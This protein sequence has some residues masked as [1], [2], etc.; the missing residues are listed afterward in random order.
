MAE[1][2]SKLKKIMSNRLRNRFDAVSSWPEGVRNT[3]AMVSGERS[4]GGSRGLMYRP[5][6]GVVGFRLVHQGLPMVLL[7][8]ECVSCAR[9]A[10]SPT[11]GS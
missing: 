10:S 4:G 6:H 11:V 8:R 7:D 2:R 1:T 5:T 9:R 3:G